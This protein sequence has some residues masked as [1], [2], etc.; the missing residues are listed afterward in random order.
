MQIDDATRS[1][2]ERWLLE[3]TRIPTASGR[4][5]RVIEWI[6]RW[7][8]ERGLLLERDPHENLVVRAADP[9]GPGPAVYVTAHLD[10]PAFVVDRVLAPGTLQLEFRGGVMDEYFDEADIVVHADGGR[11]D[12]RISR[13]LEGERPGLKLYE[14]E[15]SSE[16]AVDVGDVATWSLPEPEVIDGVFHTNAC[17][18]LA[19]VAA[20]L[21]AFD[22]L[23]GAGGNR[24]DVRLLFTRAE[25]IGFIGAIG[26]CKS[27]TMP[28]D[29]RVIALE[30]SRAFA[31][32][33]IGGGP[34]VRVGDRMSVFSPSLTSAIAKRAEDV[35]GGS[36]HV[37]SVQKDSDAPAWR[38]QR[39]L[40]AGGACE[41]SVFCVYGYEATCLCLPLGNYHNM[42]D[43]DAVQAQTNTTRPR[44]G[45]EH[46]ALG[47][48]RGLVD[49]LVAC[50]A[51]LP[52]RAPLGERLEG[53]Y[54]ERAS[55]L[56]ER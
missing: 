15:L 55:V 53:L 8:G 47:D 14:A 33:P 31:D 19:A 23:L 40:M 41:A 45:R 9:W 50:G 34:I 1:A 32:S 49:L 30:N 46:I 37:L 51:E 38:W 10:H 24:H 7:A 52:E 56:D 6:E 21:A 25:E 54:S 26:A 13:K 43:L 4:E 36:A 5:R 29:S 11:L 16:G 27:G 28:S 3:L 17:D 35:S 48:Y 22:V 18:D 44:V 42:A 2:H 39:K 12:A 20:A